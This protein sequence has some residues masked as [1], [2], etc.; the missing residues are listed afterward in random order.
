M[1]KTWPVIVVIIALV[2]FV[3]SCGG[4]SAPADDDTPTAPEISSLVDA[5]ATAVATSV[6]TD[7]MAY[8]IVTFSTGMDPD[9]V[10]TADNITLVC[11]ISETATLTTTIESEDDHSF[12][13]TTPEGFNVGETC[14]MTFT[15]NI[16]S[17]DDL[18]L[19]EAT[20]SFAIT[21]GSSP[22][23]T[24]TKSAEDGSN[25][26][27][28]SAEYPETRL[29]VKQ[30]ESYFTATFSEE[31]NQNTVTT[32]GAAPTVVLTCNDAE[33]PLTEPA[34][35]DSETFTFNVD[36]VNLDQYTSCTLLFGSGIVASSGLSFSQ[37]SFLFKT[38][39]TTDDDFV[40]DTVG[41]EDDDDAQANCW[42]YSTGI[43]T[44][45]PTYFSV[46]GGM[47]VY[48][49]TDETGSAVDFMDLDG[50]KL[51]KTFSPSALTATIAVSNPASDDDETCSLM[52]SQIKDNSA[53]IVM[54]SLYHDSCFWYIADC[55]D[56]DPAGCAA[57]NAGFACPHDPTEEAPLYLQISWAPTDTLTLKYG[58]SL[59][60]L[61]TVDIAAR[62]LTLDLDYD[63][64]VGIICSSNSKTFAQRI[65]SFTV[66][67]TATGPDAEDD[68]SAQE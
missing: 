41:F 40:T 25:S 68:N 1:K 39:C 47:L 45:R 54:L 20:Y 6:T 57:E 5:T 7:G 51:Y 3:I 55:I 33:V 63:V 11:S 42:N 9:S 32:T 46:S 19:E 2:G 12:R 14:D 59:D 18:A 4:S 30:E 58:L 62:D 37:T 23:V 49:T 52:I 22:T 13:I 31:V 29:S 16:K 50:E 65:G 27:A 8:F 38:G 66:N 28:L 26:T 17:S 61:S 21:A 64:N 60:S 34:T 36:G 44:K 43:A 35:T 10:T 53:G 67:T 48:N 56:I 24:V 15:V